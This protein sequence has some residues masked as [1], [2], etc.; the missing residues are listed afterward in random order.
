MSYIFWTPLTFIVWTFFFFFFLL[1]ST[2]ESVADKPR[3]ASWNQRSM[4][5]SEAGASVMCLTLKFLFAYSGLVS[6]LVPCCK[7]WW[8]GRAFGAWPRAVCAR[9]APLSSK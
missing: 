8:S 4:A 9:S 7:F 1:C 5:G 3:P 6:G 2:D